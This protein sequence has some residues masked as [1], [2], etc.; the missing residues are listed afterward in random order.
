[1]ND[2]DLNVAGLSLGDTKLLEEFSDDTK[3]IEELGEL[4]DEQWKELS[5][6]VLQRIID[7]LYDLQRK[8]P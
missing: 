4:T 6:R 3:L 1:M 7:E 2:F 5:A 8:K